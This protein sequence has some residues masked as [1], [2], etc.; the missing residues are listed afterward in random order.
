MGTCHNMNELQKHYIKW[1]KPIVKHSIFY[2][3]VYFMW[4]DKANQ[5]SNCLKLEVK[6]RINCRYSWGNFMGFWKCSKCS[7]CWLLSMV[8]QHYKFIKNHWLHTLVNFNV[9]KLHFNKTVKIFNEFQ[10]Y[11][12]I[13]NRQFAT[14]FFW[15]LVTRDAWRNGKRTNLF[16]N[17][18]TLRRVYGGDQ[19]KPS[20]DEPW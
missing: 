17:I 15:D 18:N 13:I 12:S 14:G 19:R 2:D 7:K 9:Y 20:R 4:P 8:A 1:K 11:L 5:V 6:L 3:F 16:R 10:K